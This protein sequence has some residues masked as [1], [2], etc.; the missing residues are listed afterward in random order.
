MK[1]VPT[2]SPEVSFSEVTEGV[3]KLNIAT[4]SLFADGSD[5]DHAYKNQRAKMIPQT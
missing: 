5:S 2:T 3:E 4:F 1:N